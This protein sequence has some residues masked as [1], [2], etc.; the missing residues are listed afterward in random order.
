MDRYIILMLS[1]YQKDRFQ[2][3]YSHSVS[4]IQQAQ[5]LLLWR[6]AGLLFKKLAS[7]TCYIAQ[8]MRLDPTSSNVVHTCKWLS[9]MTKIWSMLV[10]YKKLWHLDV[11]WYIS[12]QRKLLTLD[13]C[14]SMLHQNLL[15]TFHPFFSHI[16]ISPKH[17]FHPF[18]S[19]P[20][21]PHLDQ[22]SSPLRGP[23]DCQ[24]HDW[25]FWHLSEWS[26]LFFFFSPL[27]FGCIEAN[28]N[29]SHSF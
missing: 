22:S 4:H 6:F 14:T 18:L 28:S 10:S 9:Q 11:Y 3:K 12:V 19:G 20:I 17:T 29:K 1:K 15:I 5:D 27:T 25:M 26:S 2:R 24:D 8:G 16:K 7:K 23:W 13:P 21:L